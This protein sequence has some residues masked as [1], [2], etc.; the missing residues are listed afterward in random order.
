MDWI[1]SI[2]MF[3]IS[4][5]FIVIGF[6]DKSLLFLTFGALILATLGFII[7]STG[8]NIPMGWVVG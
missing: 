4:S 6:K 8:L 5:F 1:I 7:L 3:L 2:A